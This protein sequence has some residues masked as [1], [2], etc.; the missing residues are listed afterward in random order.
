MIYTI[1][2]HPTLYKGVLFRS[3]LEA[4]WAAFFDLNEWQWEY[5]PIDLKGWVPDF[6][7]VIPCRRDGEHKLY[8][9]VK[10]YSALEEFKDHPVTKIEPYSEPSP[11]MFGLSPDVTFWQ[12]T[13]GDGGGC[14]DVKNWVAY[15]SDQTLDA[16]EL[17]SEA[18]NMTRW[19][20]A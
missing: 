20:P 2:A 17:W 8:I 14:E 5:E 16:D 11:A 6:L 1:K 13:H 4:R 18:G 12:M 7:L 9:E 3:R 10:P 15:C 19:I